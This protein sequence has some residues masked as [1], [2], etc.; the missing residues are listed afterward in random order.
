MK[1]G[2]PSSVQSEKVMEKAKPGEV[3]FGKPMFNLPLGL[4][5]YCVHN[6]C[7]EKR[8]S[9]VKNKTTNFDEFELI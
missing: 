5:Q 6:K 1:F 8:N 7:K 9:K 4:V 3:R 2:L